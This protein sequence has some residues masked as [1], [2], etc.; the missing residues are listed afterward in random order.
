[1]TAANSKTGDGG[2]WGYTCEF[3]GFGNSGIYCCIELDYPASDTSTRAS[4]VE[5]GAQPI[6][7]VRKIEHE[8]E[9]WLVAVLCL[10]EV[11]GG[12]QK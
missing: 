10:G 12:E 2:G 1:M 4:D 9:R 5:A 8:R 11:L 7:S 3:G 6:A